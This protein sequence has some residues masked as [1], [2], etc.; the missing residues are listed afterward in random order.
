MGIE[1][2]KEIMQ[3]YFDELMTNRD[4]S[5]VDE[6]LH[7]DFIAVGGGGLKGV[8]GHKQ[9]NDYLH[10][11]VSDARFEVQQMIAEGDTVAVFSEWSG[12][13]DGSTQ[14]I[15]PTGNHVSFIMAA[16]YEFKDGKILRGAV[17]TLS[18]HLSMYQQMGILPSTEE[19]IKTY[20]ETHNLE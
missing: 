9:Y 16:V 20:K 14:G 1:E 10:S 15:P 2:N 19:I 7:Q 18:N 12:T 17:R 13:N 5:R 3:R 8:E 4:Y 11:V 6:I